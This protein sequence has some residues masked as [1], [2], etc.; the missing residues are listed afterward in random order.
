M[1]NLE[2]IVD[3]GAKFLALPCAV[4]MFVV[5]V[6]RLRRGMPFVRT[7]EAQQLEAARLLRTETEDGSASPHPYEKGLLYRMLARSRLVSFREIDLL[8]QLPDPF[9]YIDVLASV[10]GLFDAEERHG[11]WPFEFA[12]RY[13][14]PAWRKV[15]G[16]IA[17]GAALLL[18]PAAVMPVFAVPVY[19]L[20]YVPET[21]SVEQFRGIAVELAKLA[22]LSLL[23]FGYPAVECAR[24]LVRMQ[25]AEGLVEAVRG[26]DP[27]GAACWPG[28]TQAAAGLQ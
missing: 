14:S 16:R 7:T 18:A 23:V 19:H 24:W 2:V 9:R 17:G 4:L 12:G 22:A 11:G 21:V 26:L 6:Q 8:L 13:G 10:R 20:L 1:G 27:R 5:L 25:R 15:A 28:G 3:F